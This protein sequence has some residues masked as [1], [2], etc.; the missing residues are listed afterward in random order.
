VYVGDVEELH[1]GLTEK[2]HAGTRRK[3][4]KH[5]PLFSE[6]IIAERGER[7]EVRGKQESS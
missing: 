7:I 4:V 2:M 5:E 6:T 3:I 1:N